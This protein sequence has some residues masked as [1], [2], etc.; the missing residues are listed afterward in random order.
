[1]STMAM[2][3][4]IPAG[5]AYSKDAVMEASAKSAITCILRD[6]KKGI[7]KVPEEQSAYIE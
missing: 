1:M 5:M 3:M 7:L 2:A 6:V 4:A